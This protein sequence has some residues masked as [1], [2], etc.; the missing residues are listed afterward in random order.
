VRPEELGKLGKNNSVTSPEI[1]S[2]PFRLVGA[3]KYHGTAEWPQCIHDISF[4]DKMQSMQ[5]LL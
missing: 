1:E 4:T 3:G 2:A 5:D